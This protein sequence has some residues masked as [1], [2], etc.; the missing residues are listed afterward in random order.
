MTFLRKRLNSFK[1]AFTGI[2]T[3][4]KTQT[5]PK[6]HLFAAIAVI[7]AGFVFEVSATEWLVL[8]LAIALVLAAEAFNSALEMLCD[9]VTTE[10]HPLIKNVKDISAGAVLMSAITSVIIGLIIFIPK[11]IL[12]LQMEVL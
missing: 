8:I 5:H 4:F 10:E 9:K 11:V 2:G 6:I 12:F 1:Y 3:F 7:A